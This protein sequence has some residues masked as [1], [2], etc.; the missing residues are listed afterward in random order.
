M[1]DTSHLIKNEENILSTPKTACI[2]KNG[3]LYNRLASSSAKSILGKI[4]EKT[5]LRPEMKDE[6]EILGDRCL[7]TFNSNMLKLIVSENVFLVEEQDTGY[8]LFSAAYLIRGVFT[9][10]WML[11]D[12]VY[13]HNLVFYFNLDKMTIGWE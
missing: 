12:S 13:S 2:L 3:L 1:V 10:I 9:K 8:G 4:F 7:L 11:E 5:R 6:Q